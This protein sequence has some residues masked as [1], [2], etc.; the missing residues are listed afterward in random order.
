MF[1]FYYRSG[2]QFQHAVELCLLSYPSPLEEDEADFVIRLYLYAIAGGIEYAAVFTLAILATALSSMCINFQWWPDYADNKPDLYLNRFIIVGLFAGF[3]YRVKKSFYAGSKQISKATTTTPLLRHGT[4]FLF[5]NNP[6]LFYHLA[7]RL[8]LYATGGWYLSFET[9]YH[10]A[11]MLISPSWD[12]W[13]L[14]L[15]I[16]SPSQPQPIRLTNVD[17]F[18]QCLFAGFLILVVKFGPRHLVGSIVSAQY[19]AHQQVQVQVVQPSKGRGPKSKAEQQPAAALHRLKL[20]IESI[21][22]SFS[23]WLSA[24]DIH[25]HLHYYAR[26][27]LDWLTCMLLQLQDTSNILYRQDEVESHTRHFRLLTVLPGLGDTPIRCLLT[28]HSVDDNRLAY[29]A[30]SYCWGLNTPSHQV[31]VNGTPLAVTRSAFEVLHALRSCYRPTTLWIDYICID[32]SSQK[33]KMEQLP[34][35]PTIFQN[36]THVT[37][38]LGRSKTAHLAIALINRLFIYNRLGNVLSNNGYRYEIP[39]KGARA[40]K[41]MLK[42]SWFTRVWVIQEVVSARRDIT[43]RYGNHSIRWERFSWF[44]QCLQVDSGLLSL[45]ERRIGYDGLST[46]AALQNL[47]LMRRFA[48]IKNQSQPFT[49]YLTSIYRSLCVF[50]ATVTHDRIY[51]LAGLSGLNDANYFHK[52][53]YNTPLNELFIDV[54]KK[55]L[56]TASS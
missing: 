28:R 36:A 34:L 13:L 46:V 12:G 21:D 53:N 18:Q 40:L 19:R 55:T 35:M 51:A 45:L 31:L 49:F 32:Q 27:A 44:I 24:F 25:T 1:S 23:V 26:R 20:I 33:D 50:N 10:A 22:N 9:M 39:V 5:W 38:W 37:V 52:T 41:R 30:V 43:I 17:F 7:Q 2:H 54:V 16:V 14:P 56:E 4:A 8:I 47:S 42:V 29:T 11:L 3:A 48:L 6:G 15:Y